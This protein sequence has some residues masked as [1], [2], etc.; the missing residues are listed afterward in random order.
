[1]GDIAG[2]LS[3]HSKFEDASI[4]NII[5][6][7]EAP[8]GLNMNY[9]LEYI[10]PP[11]DPNY[12]TERLEQ[13]DSCLRP[14]QKFILKVFYGIPLDTTPV[15]ELEKEFEE[16]KKNPL[17]APRMH[18][19]LDRR[20]RVTDMF[21]DKVLFYFNEK[22]YLEYLFQE[23]RCNIRE[24]VPGKAFQEFA[25]V[26]GRR[27]GKSATSS[28]ISAYE[29]YKLLKRG[30]PQAYY[31]L[32]ENSEIFITCVATS[33]DQ[34]K[35]LFNDITSNLNTC[36]Y[37]KRY[38]NDPTLEK[39]EIRTPYHLEKYGMSARPNLI[40]RAAPCSAKGLRGPANIVVILDEVAHF[41][42]SSQNKSDSAVYEA[43]VPSLASFG[44]DGKLILIS[45]PLAKQGKLYEGYKNA[46]EG[47]EGI[48]TM[49]LPS[50]ELNPELKATFLRREWHKNPTVYE[51]EY[52]GQFSDKIKAW[53]PYDLLETVI[54]KS[55]QKVPRGIPK[56]PYYMGID[57]GLKKDPTS[58][59]I[60]HIEHK[61]N[62]A[63]IEVPTII[64]DYNDILSSTDFAFN[65]TDF[66]D[67]DEVFNWIENLC[68]DFYIVGGLMDQAYG[69][70]LHQKLIKQGFNQ[71]EMEYFTDKKN[72]DV[73]QNF[74][75]QVVNGTVRLY[76][77]PQVHSEEG[78]DSAKE[79]G[80]LITEIINL[81]ETVKAKYISKVHA[82]P[83]EGMHDDRADAT[84]RAV[85]VASQAI[86][87]GDY[88]VKKDNSTQYLRTAITSRAA[89]QRN[90]MVNHRYSDPKRTIKKR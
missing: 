18:I 6:F 10:A 57:L 19:K 36:T 2:L 3:Q 90:K 86:T 37:F 22:D 60:C 48:L 89:Y 74:F 23:G 49:V 43:V 79:H 52:G 5:D 70:P 71:F 72:S 16:K 9:G 44:E 17:Y 54:D 21:N 45:S 41:T 81:Q 46:M 8:W 64:L 15:S 51:C 24:V 27:G 56:T 25:L 11:R 35:L 87:R 80:E 30:H 82:P 59:S 53:M 84:V 4:A 14:V 47:A 61:F 88:E 33:I 69:P 42:D 85:W 66:L 76:D 50:W 13:G 1:M 28:I 7:C 34:S 29:E 58:I 65:D 55:L 63:G 31:G 62:E 12:P 75:L 83:I 77:D 32:K 39:M 67:F 26:A 38:K 78:D 73:F 68:K 20:I 40:L